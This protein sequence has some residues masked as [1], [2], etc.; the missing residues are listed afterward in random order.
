[1]SSP[2]SLL[3][4]D[5]E[6][7]ILIVLSA[8]LEDMGYTVA[9]ASSGRKALELFE[10]T[11]PALVMTDIKMPGMDGIELLKHIKAIDGD[12]EVIMLTGHGDMDLA[13]ESL[14]HGAGDFLNK[15]VS[16]SA[17]EVALDRAKQRIGLRETLRR[18]TDEL[19]RLVE[20][21]TR[22]LLES[23]R[24]AAVG[25]TA[26]SLAHTI[27]NIAGALEGTM[28]VLERG[29]EQNKREY[30]EQGWQMV[31][32]DIAR[33]RHLAMGLLDLGRPVSLH[34]SPCDPDLPAREV[35][36]LATAK[37]AEMGVRLETILRAGPEPFVLDARSVHHCLL[38]LVLN[39]LEACA[40][41]GTRRGGG[42]VRFSSLRDNT[43]NGES[44][45]YIIEDNGFGVAQKLEAGPVGFY[46]TKEGGSGIGLFSTRKTAHE[47]GAELHFFE[48][49]GGGV[50]AV[51]SVKQGSI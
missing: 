31:C 6:E 46:S 8:L 38:N 35:A 10:T 2:A 24:F 47:M 7:G 50:K 32:A 28:F 36:E 42:F 16:D 40:V 9:K 11:R 14:R 25:E 29:L 13:V 19:E 4:V 20:Q 39:A 49:E 22:E 17:V 26:A 15:P 3:L 1:M 43:V 44:I 21:R 34:L 45:V 30:F 12:A 33:L 41:A 37:A 51:L 5:D 27:K 23:E 18:H 48:Q